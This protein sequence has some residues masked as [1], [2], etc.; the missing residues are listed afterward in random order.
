MG[1]HVRFAKVRG[2]RATFT[3][4]GLGVEWIGPVGPTRGSA[5]VWINGRRIKTVSTH[6]RSFRAARVLFRMNWTSVGTRTMTIV[7][8]G[9]KG[10]PTVAIDAFVVREISGPSERTPVS[11][12]A[13]FVTRV[14]SRLYLG[15]RQ[16]RFDGLNIYQAIAAPCWRMA[17]PFQLDSDL[18]AI[19]SGQ[20][21]ARVFA[22]QHT[23]TTNG[24]RDWSYMDAALATFAAHDV[25][26]IMV[27]TDQ[28]HSQPCSDT[29]TDRTRGWYE[30]GYKSAIEGASTY[31]E[32]VAQ[33]VARYRDNPTIAMW[34]LVNEAAAPNEDGSCSWSAATDA[35]RCVR[36]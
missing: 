23:A 6:A 21:V 27:L 22:F 15:D 36:G 19:G 16:F 2:A 35:L 7:V 4:K 18:A 26:V 8:N 20:E 25:R 33:V 13:G 17:F 12:S 14:G 29:S 1:G 9:T 24:E 28:W 10:H 5:T 32:W 30:E 31:R 11:A 3:F 34:Q